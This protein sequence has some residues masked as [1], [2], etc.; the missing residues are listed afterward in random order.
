EDVAP[1]GRNCRPP[2]C[3]A[4]ALRDE[5]N[6]AVAHADVHAAGVQADRY[7]LANTFAAV[8]V[9][10]VHVVLAKVLAG[11]HEELRGRPGGLMRKPRGPFEPSSAAPAALP[12][13][14]G[15]RLAVFLG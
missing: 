5:A 11:Q 14:P 8:K 3:G 15:A 2:G 4:D 1:V 13:I 10:G 12:R 9:R 7:L 6:A